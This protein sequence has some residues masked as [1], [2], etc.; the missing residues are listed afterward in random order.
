MHCL[1]TE[2]VS[3]ESTEQ[4]RWGGVALQGGRPGGPC[5]RHGVAAHLLLLLCLAKQL[6]WLQLLRL[7]LLAWP[8]LL[9]SQVAAAARWRRRRE[10]LLL[11][12]PWAV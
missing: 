8:Q 6:L 10:Q 2:Q 1:P 7:W 3:L 4:P 5:R 12:A 11:H 9:G